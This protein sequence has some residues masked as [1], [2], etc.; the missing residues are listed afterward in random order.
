M[1]SVRKSIGT[2]LF[3]LLAVALVV[4]VIHLADRAASTPDQVGGGTATYNPWSATPAAVFS[5]PATTST[6]SPAAGE[7]EDGGSDGGGDG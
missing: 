5:T 7:P 1:E 2:I 6:P 4:A 3:T